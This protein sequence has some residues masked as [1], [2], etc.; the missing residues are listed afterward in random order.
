MPSAGHGG[1]GSHAGGSRTPTQLRALSGA[2]KPP[3]YRHHALTPARILDGDFRSANLLRYCPATHTPR[4]SAAA[5]RS[6]EATRSG[7]AGPPTDRR[8]LKRVTDG[9]R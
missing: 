9:T 6:R 3:E 2:R 4:G 8:P 7:Q 5:E 1:G